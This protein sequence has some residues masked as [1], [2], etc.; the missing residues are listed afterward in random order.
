MA[1]TFLDTNSLMKLYL[2]ELGSTWLKNYILDKVVVISELSLFESLSVGRR[3]HLEGRL[4]L[5]EVSDLFDII[6]A[7]RL[8]F[9]ILNLG[10]EQQFKDL[11]NIMLNLPTTLRLRALD[12]LQLVAAEIALEFANN[13][14]P[15]EPF[16][17]VS[18]DAQLLRVAQARGLSIENPENYP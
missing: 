4:T 3:Q 17:F 2:T 12:G 7:D 14:T 16:V 10:G 18:S 13:L 5:I 8:K 9:R 15:P 6:N 1:V 11:S